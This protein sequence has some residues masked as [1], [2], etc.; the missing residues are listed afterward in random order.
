MSQNYIEARVNRHFTK[1]LLDSG[2][3]FS[4]AHHDFVTKTLNLPLRVSNQPKSVI[5]AC[6][7]C[8]RLQNCVTLNICVSGLS[9]THT[10][11]VS[12]ALSKKFNVIIGLDFLKA[13]NAKCDFASNLVSFDNEQALT[14]LITNPSPGTILHPAEGTTIPPLSETIFSLTVPPQF[15]GKQIYLEPFKHP[16]QLLIAHTVCTAHQNRVPCKVLNF[17]EQPIFVRPNTRLVQAYFLPISAPLSVIGNANISSSPDSCTDDT[18]HANTFCTLSEQNASSDFDRSPDE[19]Y[20]QLQNMNIDLSK[21]T[22]SDHDKLDF[23]KLILQNS[24]L[25]AKNQFDIGEYPYIEHDIPLKPGTQPFFERNYP[26]S[27][28]VKQIIHDQV[29]KYLNAGIVQESLSPFNSNILAIRKR[30]NQFRICA[31][32]R[33]L[34]RQTIL[35][36][37]QTLPIADDIL[38]NIAD[39]KPAIFSTIDINQAYMHVRL[40]PRSCPLTSFS[41]SGTTYEYCRMVPGL[42]AATQTF[43]RIGERILAGINHLYATCYLDDFIIYSR[44]IQTHKLHLQDIFDRLRKAN[45]KISA[46]KCSWATS[47]IKFLGF[48]IN[49]QGHRPDP[50]RIAAIQRMETPSSAKQLKSCLAIFNYNRKYILNFS[51]ISRVLYSLLK[52][53][54]KWTW[55]SIHQDAFDQLKARLKDPIFL[56]HP[57]FTQPFHLYTDACSVSLAFSLH[58]WHNG[59]EKI[60]SCGSRFLTPAQ[61][62][63]PITTLETMAIIFG[64]HQC[65]PFIGPSQTVT[66]F[67]DHISATYLQTLKASR[68][69]LY[70]LAL[71]LEEYQAVIKFVPG[72][73]NILANYLS[74]HPITQPAEPPR[75]PDLIHPP[76]PTSTPP[77]TP[78]STNYVA[79]N[80]PPSTLTDNIPEFDETIIPIVD[81]N[82]TTI[83]NIID[84]R[85][86]FQISLDSTLPALFED[87]DSN[88]FANSTELL[89]QQ[90]PTAQS[91]NQIPT[92]SNFSTS[93]HCD[94]PDA[95]NLL[96]PPTLCDFNEKYKVRNLPSIQEIHAAQRDDVTL[97]PLI[98]YL[99]TDTL[100]VDLQAA[101]KLFL[102]AEQFML[103]ENGLLLHLY[104]NRRSKVTSVHKHHIQIVI[105]QSLTS[106]FLHA[107][108]DDLIHSGVNKLFLQLRQDFFWTAMYRSCESY[109]KS[110][111]ACQLSK[112]VS[113]HTRVPTKSLDP[114]PEPMHSVTC[115]FVGPLTLIPNTNY[116]HILSIQCDFSRMVWLYPTQSQD[117]KTFIA[118]L[119]NFFC[120]FGFPSFIR[121]DR[122]SAFLADMTKSFFKAYAIKHILSS[123]YKPTSQ[124]RLERLH[125]VLGSILRLYPDVTNH[126]HD[127]L[128]AI[129]YGINSTPRLELAN[130]SPA[131]LFFGRKFSP[132]AALHLR[133]HEHISRNP[134]FS[135]YLE[136]LKQKFEIIRDTVKEAEKFTQDVNKSRLDQREP[137]THFKDGQKVLFFRV[138]RHLE[139]AKLTPRFNEVF[140]VVEPDYK[141]YTVKLKNTDG[142]VLSTRVHMSKLKPYYSAD[143]TSPPQPINPDANSLPP[144][145]ADPPPVIPQLEV[146]QLSPSQ[147][148]TTAPQSHKQQSTHKSS[149]I[150]ISTRQSARI[151]TRS[152]TTRYSA[153]HAPKLIPK[154]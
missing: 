140:E 10:F 7:K 16:Q 34:N 135:T 124:S 43:Q 49:D 19:I 109:V 77:T 61:S 99:E 8:L 9:M 146:N 90:I 151:Q 18:H 37:H 103:N 62:N 15:N 91:I 78:P 153:N 134:N 46:S 5:T 42:A 84:S 104:T 112:N 47:E 141:F 1:I 38:R 75:A 40:T 73:N 71:K 66:V 133:D 115:D 95:M 76:A 110:C 22:L 70:R 83:T 154:T 54:A 86:S 126:W 35:P 3:N 101:R 150:P 2:S 20:S 59:I 128:P 108:H 147:G 63:Y 39:A 14:K 139:C 25:F 29:Q 72:K 36:V 41:S 17:T 120:Q 100:P 118:I 79:L 92:D 144:T 132:V 113:I 107:F 125:R 89:N 80:G 67:T 28:E 6:G 4:V 26:H 50:N 44:D 138:P 117:A 11:F 148:D 12:D 23:A 45:L 145:F 52:Q 74:R 98:E 136:Q 55:T 27:P 33:R 130:I 82:P 88:C 123:S 65:R 143:D 21:C 24:D 60:V 48:I 64:L 152:Y 142:I 87:T 122:G 13:F 57:D 68:G 51:K 30:N 32:M 129:S 121:T 127:F 96:F 106:R 137:F 119:F 111:H 81:I 53:N 56:S 149:R 58:Q 105:P 85:K 69:L 93:S 116:R 31:D 102:I 97:Q 114:S 131:E 94:H